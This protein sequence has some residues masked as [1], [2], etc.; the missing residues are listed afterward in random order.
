MT[1]LIMGK[2][3]VPGVEGGRIGEKKGA[4]GQLFVDRLKKN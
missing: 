2:K 3:K 4:K 1:F